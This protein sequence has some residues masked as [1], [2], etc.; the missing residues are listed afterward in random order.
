MAQAA[1][2]YLN[3][4]DAAT[5]EPS[6]LGDLLLALSGISGSFAAAR[7]SIMA[8]FAAAE[9]HDADGYGS[10]ATWLTAVGKMTRRDANAQVKEM[11]RLRD[12]PELH[13]ALAARLVSGSWAE[14]IA[15]LTDRFPADVRGEIDGL[16]VS[17]AQAGTDLTDLAMVAQAAYE[18]WR[19]SQGPDPDEPGDGSDGDPDDGGFAER[20]VRLG[21]TLDGVGRLNGKLTKE[22]GEA[23]QAVLDALS[24]K[25]GPEDDRTEGQRCHDALQWACELLLR[26]GMVP[27]RKGADTR[28]EAVVGLMQLRGMDG[29]SAVEEAW[30][31]STAGEHG[32][33]AGKDAEVIACDALIVP[34]V[35][36]HPDLDVVDEMIVLMAR[37]L[38]VDLDARGLEP[39]GHGGPSAGRA[40]GDG[41]RAGAPDLGQARS[42]STRSMPLTPRGWPGLRY[43]IAR[44]AID[45]VSGPG[46]LASVLRQNLLDAPYNGKSVVLDIGFS[47][48][49][50]PSVRRAVGLRAKGVCEWPGC[51]RRGSWCDV[52]HIIH[53]KDGGETSTW[54]CAML[55]QFHHDI[56]VHRDGWRFV[57]HSDASTSAYGPGGQELHSH[58]PPGAPGTR[59]MKPWPVAS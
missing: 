33:L 41:D 2:D 42:S 21:T 1:A 20:S 14:Q 11:R 40:A 5:L 25:A 56:C 57:L 50:P 47:E 51:R 9:A 23:L 35:T 38:G 29:A 39:F 30:L 18:A 15:R 58:G 54:N 13:E 24:K 6:G 16:L 8:R 17:T 31:A 19:Q 10:P 37:Y 49:I 59:H 32:Y 7:A 55:C 45:L 34:I 3:G 27:Q 12:H 28:V 26:A 53:K 52:H 22:C 48:T 44:L 4:P 43:A 46:G 36:G